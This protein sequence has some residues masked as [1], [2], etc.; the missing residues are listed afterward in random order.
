V[1]PVGGNTVQDLLHIPPDLRIQGCQ[2]WEG[3]MEPLAHTLSGR[4]I[5]GFLFLGIWEAIV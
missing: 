2:H 5:P 3:R 1:D 4:D